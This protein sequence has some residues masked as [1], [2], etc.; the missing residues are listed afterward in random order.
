MFD[1]FFIGLES[2]TKPAALA[3]PKRSMLLADAPA[4]RA[5]YGSCQVG[6]CTC[7]KYASAG[8]QCTNCSHKFEDHNP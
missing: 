1:G 8:W 3:P 2:F 4:P 7:M 6:G 5:G